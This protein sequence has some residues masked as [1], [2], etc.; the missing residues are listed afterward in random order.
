[1]TDNRINWD[2]AHV[3]AL[4]ERLREIS[5]LLPA[6]KDVVR[7]CSKRRLKRESDVD[8]RYHLALR[9]IN[10]E[11]DILRGAA[12]STMYDLAVLAAA[13][14]N[15]RRAFERVCNIYNIDPNSFDGNAGKQ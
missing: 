14:E 9:A 7:A 4:Y 3:C 1:M 12:K 5:L 15:N 13:S 10:E 2:V 6:T 11:L 8:R